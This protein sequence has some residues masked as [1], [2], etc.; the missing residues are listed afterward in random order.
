VADVAGSGR[1]A[2]KVAIVTGA[3][4]GFGEGIARRYCA[5]GARVLLADLNGETAELIAKDLRQGGHD[6]VAVAVDVSVDAEVRGAVD[7]AV[8]RW[9]RVD[10]MVNNAG[11]AQAPTAIEDATDELFHQLAAVNMYGVFAGC[12]AV[13]PVMKAQGQGVIINTASTAAV[14][15]RPLLNLYNA[16]K[17][18]VLNL[19]KTLALELAPHQIRVNAINPVMGDTGMLKVFTGEESMDNRQRAEVVSTIP[20][21]RM[22]T[23]DD[24]AWAAVYLASDEASLV[25]GHGLEVDGGRDV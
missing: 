1:L 22:S 21:G 24:I 7:T 16:S 25:T 12:R 5:E 15:P 3:A 19:T 14:R 4:S 9:G 20:L 2:G 13:V 18:F 17:A 10:I 6:A 11:I 8:K 23:P